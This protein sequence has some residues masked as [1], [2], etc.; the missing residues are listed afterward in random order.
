MLT[1]PCPAKLQGIGSCI[2]MTDLKKVPNPDGDFTSFVDMK[3]CIYWNWG[4]LNLMR[5][6]FQDIHIIYTTS[7]EFFSPKP[8]IIMLQMIS[9]VCDI[10]NKWTLDKEC[11]IFFSFYHSLLLMCD[12]NQFLKSKLPFWHEILHTEEVILDTDGKK[13]TETRKPD[14]WSAILLEKDIDQ[15]GKVWKLIKKNLN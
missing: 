15:K 4:R 14:F 2:H 12:L 10:D 8:L 6:L 5:H 1:Y 3:V 11:L 7:I 13:A 9:N